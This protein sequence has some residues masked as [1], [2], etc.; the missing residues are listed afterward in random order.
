MNHEEPGSSAIALTVFLKFITGALAPVGRSQGTPMLLMGDEVRRTQLGNNNAYCQDNELSWFDWSLVAQHDGLLR[1]V[2]KLIYFIQGL[3]IFRQEKFLKVSHVSQEPHLI[4]HGQYLG[5]PDWSEDSHYLAFSLFHP[6]SGEH[7]HVILN[8]YWKPL[9]FE[10]P[11]LKS[12]YWH[13]I[14][15][16]ALATPDDFSDLKAAVKIHEDNYLVTGRSSLVLMES[17]NFIYE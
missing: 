13:R 11:P 15:D 8:A 5:E 6:D 14:I 12:G 4:W 9:K 2:K 3:E 10:L 17:R 16:T 7:L 1:F